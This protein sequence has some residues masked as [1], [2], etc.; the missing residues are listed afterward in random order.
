MTTFRRMPRIMAAIETILLLVSFQPRC[1]A[2]PIAWINPNGG[3]YE[4]GSN[5]AGV[6]IPDPS[7]EALFGWPG[8]YKVGFLFDGNEVAELNVIDDAAVEFTPGGTGGGDRTFSV[9]GHSKIDRG[10]LTLGGNAD[11]GRFHMMNVDDLFTIDGIPTDPNTGVLTIRDNATL[12]SGSVV[13]GSGAGRF[14]RVLLTGDE[15]LWTQPELVSDLYVGSFNG[16]GG[17]LTVEHGA[18]LAS[19][20]TSIGKST[21][22]P[23]ESNRGV[24][25]VRGVGSDGGPS[26]WETDA[27]AVIGHTGKGVLQIE[28]GARVV[29]GSAIVAD[30]PGAWGQVEVTGTDAAGNPSTWSTGNLRTAF[31][32]G[33]AELV[34]ADGARVDTHRAEVSGSGTTEAVVRGTGA[35]GVPTTWTIAELLIVGGGGSGVLAIE[36]GSHVSSVETRIAGGTV[37]GSGRLTVRSQTGGPVSTWNSA[38]HVYVGGNDSNSEGEGR[39]ELL[40]G[41]RAEIDGTLKVWASGTVTLQAGHLI[42]DTIDHSDGGEFD[43]RNGTLEVRRF[44]GDLVNQGGVVTPGPGIGSTAIHGDYTQQSAAAIAVDIGGIT[45]GVEYDIISVTGDASIDGELRL[46]LVNGFLPDAL[47]EFSVLGASSLSG[48]F[49]NVASGQRLETVDGDGSFVVNY[50]LGSAYDASQIVLSDFLRLGGLLGDFDNNGLLDAADIDLLSAAVG[51]YSTSYDLNSDGQITGGDRIVWV[52]DLKNTYFGD[53][54]LD[55]QFNSVDIVNVLQAGKFATNE[56]AGWN[57][58]DWDGNALFDR[59]D[60]IVA[61]QDGGYGQGTRSATSDV[62][63]GGALAAIASGGGGGDGQTSI[64]YDAVSGELSLDAPFGVGLTSINVDSAAG[65]FTGAAAK[66]LG[67]S[68]DNDSDGNIFKATFGGSFGSISFGKVGQQGLSEEFV[69]SDLSIVG[70]LAGGGDLG[71]VD[72]VY[73]PEPAALGLLS[74]GFL[75]IVTHPTHSAIRLRKIRT[76]TDKAS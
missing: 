19:Q 24:V 2:E 31:F 70:S 28:G 72:L 35:T 68:F 60:I 11:G 47:D 18:T 69:L 30:D 48:L 29:H 54:N 41:S 73:V 21:P 45:P 4:T 36:D 26:T 10:R 1:L 53:A 16:G 59:H 43:F 65:I 37:S 58:G 46:E 20:F 5:W 75:V 56:R 6:S 52:E 38:S 32:G 14:G 64:V 57:E 27:Q 7:D 3:L 12:T 23:D 42:A 17:E 22:L 50:G 51:G 13:L 67:G 44:V 74:L 34:F 33:V 40:H 9:F 49:D 55:G 61:L 8:D 76:P 63:Q 66:N 71:D 39:L 15:S 25:R 62:P